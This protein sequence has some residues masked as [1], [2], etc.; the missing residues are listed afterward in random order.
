MPLILLLFAF[1]AGA[2]APSRPDMLL[3]DTQVQIEATDAVTSLYNYQFEEADVQFRW[4]QL[5]HPGHP[6]PYFLQGLSEWW[7][8]MT[9]PDSKRFDGTFTMFMDSSIF[10]AER[11]H[12]KDARNPEPVFFLA[13]AWG[14]KG[15]LH[16]DREE[17]R[18][19]AFAGKEALQYMKKA[20]E[21]NSADFGP[22]FLFGEA[23]YNYYSVWIPENYKFLR[24]IM[25]FFPKGEKALGLKQLKE[26]ANN[27][28]YTRV[29]AQYFLMRILH[30]EEEKPLEAYP[31]ACYLDTTYPNNAF[32]TRYHARVAYSCGYWSEAETIALKILQRVNAHQIGYEATGGRYASF[33]LGHIYFS[34]NSK[35]PKAKQYLLLCKS[36]GEETNSLESGFYL[37]SLAY[38]ARI[39]IQ[40]GKDEEAKT[41]YETIEEYA[42]RKS[43][44]SKEAREFLK[45]YKKQHRKWWFF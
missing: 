30:S 28:F 18:K 20:R 16:A 24:P 25:A 1:S 10:Y 7:K 15:R 35:D 27:A 31:I 37:Y 17:W 41:Y 33:I 11:L 2:Q 26:V 13:A 19:A 39:S 40:E 5:K 4:M 6:L 21:I 36:Y 23:L 14:F 34:R 42:E 29:E 9:S 32:F 12:K 8:I 44:N 3:N 22:E 43:S 45:K 38:L